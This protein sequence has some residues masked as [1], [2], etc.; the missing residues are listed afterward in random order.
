MEG[1]ADRIA[2]A[3]SVRLAAAKTCTPLTTMADVPQE[4]E[5]SIFTFYIVAH[6]LL[7]GAAS[8]QPDH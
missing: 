6:G 3:G 2:Q 8:P 1:D 4:L 5:V 7:A